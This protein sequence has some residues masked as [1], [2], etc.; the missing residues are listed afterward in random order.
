[1]VRARGHAN[2]HQDVARGRQLFM[3]VRAI[4]PMRAGG[5]IPLIRSI[6]RTQ[7]GTFA[8]GKQASLFEQGLSAGR[9]VDI[10]IMGPDLRELVGL[11]GRDGC[12]APGPGW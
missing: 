9:T 12:L 1:M 8:I 10:E 7:P 11:G 5:L 2:A 6:G 4:N 3:G